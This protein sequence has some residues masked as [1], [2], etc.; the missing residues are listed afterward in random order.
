MPRSLEFEHDFLD[1]ACR[2]A[3]LVSIGL[4]EMAEAR[5]KLGAELYGD[6]S[7]K[8]SLDELVDN[9]EEEVVDTPCWSLLLA[10]ADAGWDLDDDTRVALVALLQSI[11]SLAAQQ[12]FLVRELRQTLKR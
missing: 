10:Q 1:E 7:L 6:E 4:T 12:T 9:I 8:L 3:G 5:L 2:G 11:T